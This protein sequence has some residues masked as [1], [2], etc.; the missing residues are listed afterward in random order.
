MKKK[1]NLMGILLWSLVLVVVG[2][3]YNGVKYLNHEKLKNLCDK[4]NPHNISDRKLDQ[5][6]KDLNELRRSKDDSSLQWIE[7]CAGLVMVEM[8]SRSFEKNFK[9][10]I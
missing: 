10:R 5:T 4:Y 7:S 9:C 8:K 6:L 2:F 3:S 1:I